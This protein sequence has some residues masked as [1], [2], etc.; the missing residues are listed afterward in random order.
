MKYDIGEI[1]IMEKEREYV[2]AVPGPAIVITK[3]ELVRIQQAP[4]DIAARENRW[5]KIGNCDRFYFGEL[6]NPY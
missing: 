2:E 4:V 3:A 1:I 5:A 6:K